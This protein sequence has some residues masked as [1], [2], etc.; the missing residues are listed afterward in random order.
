MLL[1]V[2][3]PV[4]ITKDCL[5]GPEGIASV[6]NDTCFSAVDGV[7]RRLS[8]I[9]R[10][11]TLQYRVLCSEVGDNQEWYPAYKFYGGTLAANVRAVPIRT[12]P[13]AEA[14][15]QRLTR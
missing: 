3:Y 9:A 2:I 5:G 4:K 14:W 10:Y 11:K 6:L 12:N 7:Q 1:G 8:R 13:V 15:P